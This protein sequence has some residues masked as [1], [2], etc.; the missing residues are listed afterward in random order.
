[1]AEIP[2]KELFHGRCKLAVCGTET[3]QEVQLLFTYHM[4]QVF[5][6]CTYVH[7]RLYKSYFVGLERRFF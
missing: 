6:D 1:M 2:N 3:G 7:V 4:Q 5:L